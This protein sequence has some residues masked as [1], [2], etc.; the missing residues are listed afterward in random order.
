MSAASHGVPC[1][2]SPESCTC[3]SAAASE[4]QQKGHAV[5]EKGTLSDLTKARANAKLSRP[6]GDL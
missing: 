3:S 5:S 1:S 6:Y 2:T 4:V